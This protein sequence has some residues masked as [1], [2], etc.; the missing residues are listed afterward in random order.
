MLDI[1]AIDIDTL[2]QQGRRLFDAHCAEMGLA[3]VQLD[4]PTLRKLEAV[5]TM[6][7]LG[8]YVG[9]ALIGYCVL[10]SGVHPLEGRKFLTCAA[11]FVEDR[12]RA[13]GAGLQLMHKAES[14]ARDAG[15]EV[16]YWRARSGSRL[17]RVLARFGG[18]QIESVFA[19]EL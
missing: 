14:L 18:E 4:E 17:E 19:K 6:T 13:S 10:M 7:T 8:C 1:R 2:F 5:G 3:E 16:L 15:A 9:D 11:L 12:H